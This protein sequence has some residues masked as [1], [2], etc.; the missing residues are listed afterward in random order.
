MF[1]RAAI[2]ETSKLRSLVYQEEKTPNYW[3][4]LRF[5]PIGGNFTENVTKGWKLGESFSHDND[6][7]FEYSIMIG[8]QI[9]SFRKA[10]QRCYSVGVTKRQE[11]NMEP[12]LS[13]VTVYNLLEEYI[14][15]EQLKITIKSMMDGSY[16]GMYHGMTDEDRQLAVRAI[17]GGTFYMKIGSAVAAWWWDAMIE[18]GFGSSHAE[19][20]FNPKLFWKIVGM[21]DNEEDY[22]L[23]FILA[24]A[25]YDGSILNNYFEVIVPTDELVRELFHYIFDTYLGIK[26]GSKNETLAKS[27]FEDGKDIIRISIWKKNERQQLAEK[28]LPIADEWRKNPKT[29]YLSYDRYA[30]LQSWIHL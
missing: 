20:P 1:A 18:I 10:V 3:L 8:N 24:W 27:E 29:N 6:E 13:M 22:M 2:G 25:G 21:A 17:R 26:T 4:R 14:L 12:N 5:T 19:F 9:N 28:L 15:D 23:C 11:Q 16:Q 30:N 7:K